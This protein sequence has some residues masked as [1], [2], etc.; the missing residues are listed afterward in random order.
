MM[1]VGSK[2]ILKD[3]PFRGVVIG[4]YDC[5]PIIRV[6]QLIVSNTTIVSERD[7]I[8]YTDEDGKVHMMKEP[9]T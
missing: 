4:Y 3:S 9:I 1:P 5:Y 7:I 2:V 8:S 6:D